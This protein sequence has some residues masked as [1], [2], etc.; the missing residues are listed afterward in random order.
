MQQEPCASTGTVEDKKVIAAL[1]P[2]QVASL[3]KLLSLDAEAGAGQRRTLLLDLRD[4]ESFAA[5]HI[6]GGGVPYSAP[7]SNCVQKVWRLLCLKSCMY[8]E[9]TAV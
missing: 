6:N 4:E 8:V 3:A 2:A 7:L 9:R 1:R 5:C